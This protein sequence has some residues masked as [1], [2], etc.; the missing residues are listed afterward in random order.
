MTIRKISS[1]AV[2]SNRWMTVRE[3]QIERADGSPGIYGVVEKPDFVLV[4]PIQKGGPT[5]ENGSIE[6]DQVYLVEQYRLPVAGRFAEFPQGSWEQKPG[7]DPM[8]IARGELR[9]ETGLHAGKMEYVGHLFVAYG[10]SN[11]GFHIFLATELSQGERN[12]EKEEQDLVVKR[13]A[14]A[15][16]EEMIRS[17][18]IKDAASIAAW[19]FLGIKNRRAQDSRGMLVE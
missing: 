18:E 7:A 5:E 17:G 1:R 13:V 4:I 3:H 10:M 2:Y 11:Q 12:L 19:A 16:F 9:E 14:I 15:E 6:K 8:E